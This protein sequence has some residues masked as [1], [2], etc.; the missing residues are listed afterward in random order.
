[1]MSKTNINSTKYN[2]VM[3]FNKFWNDVRNSTKFQKIN[4]NNP[5]RMEAE[6]KNK[7]NASQVGQR[8]FVINN[9]DK[10][11]FK[12]LIQNIKYKMKI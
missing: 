4:E 12:I 10:V 5:S 1:M 2:S 9:Y 8:C 6:N 11:I 7:M 3:E